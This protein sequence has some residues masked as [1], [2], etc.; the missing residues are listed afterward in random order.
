M[1]PMSTARERA[2][3]YRREAKA[4]VEVAERMSLRE[5]RERMFK[6][7]QHWLELAVI[8]EEKAARGD[9]AL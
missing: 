1:S 9:D 8:A 7:A 4:C 5:D 6:M 2:E 3:G